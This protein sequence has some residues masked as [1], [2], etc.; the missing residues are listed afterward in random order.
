MLGAFHF[1]EA[2]VMKMIINFG[3]AKSFWLNQGWNPRPLVKYNSALTTWAIQ[4]YIGGP[5]NCQLSLLRVGSHS[6][7]VKSLLDEQ[8]QFDWIRVWTWDLWFDVPALLPTELSS[9]ILAVPQIVNYFCSVKFDRSVQFPIISQS[10]INIQKAVSTCNPHD[11]HFPGLQWFIVHIVF[12]GC[13][14]PDTQHFW[15]YGF[16]LAPHPKQRQLTLWGPPI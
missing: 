12:K 14:S 7:S 13:W 11:C 6:F 1:P 15:V 4:P 8:R 16:C 9:P 3:W 5:S 10:L 2:E